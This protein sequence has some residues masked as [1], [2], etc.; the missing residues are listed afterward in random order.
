MISYPFPPNASA[1]AVRSERFARYLSR[2]SWSTNVVTIKKRNDLFVE[3]ARLDSLGDNV[4]VHHTY[5]FDPWLLL[6]EKNIKNIFMRAF[7]SIAMKLCSFPD[8]MVFWVPFAVWKGLMINKEAQINAI[9]TTSP[10][11]STHLAGLI[12]SCITHKPWI[13]DFR[14]PWTLNAYRNSGYFDRFLY[15]IEKRME[16]SVIKRAKKILANT[17]A[18]RTNMLK[19]FHWL[20]HDKVITITNGWEEF[21]LPPAQDKVN[22]KFTIVH[23]GN[24][25]SRFN[26]YGLLYALAKWKN[27]KQPEDIPPMKNISVILLGARDA[28]TKQVVQKL[29]LEGIV[30]I[31][32]W[33]P[34]SKAREIM[35]NADILWASLGTGKE[36]STYIPSKIFEYIATKTPIIGFFPEGETADLIRKTK[37]GVT[38]TSD[39]PVPI[40]RF[41]NEKDCMKREGK[42]PV[43]SPDDSVISQYD[44][45]EIVSEL[46]K[47]LNSLVD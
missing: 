30:K 22:G 25:Y 17:E 39:D 28:E 45:R 9:Y 33:M 5:T 36:A 40:I 14:D 21:L 1:G 31:E 37:T 29:N 7:R 42:G 41:L 23:S 10:P 6:R 15:F 44:I 16:I 26:P 24:F 3:S 43:Y 19:A 46:A 35:V 34:L 38:F 8:H 2:F 4:R 20:K 13:V 47:I 27:G 12:L 32:P 11:H 18:N